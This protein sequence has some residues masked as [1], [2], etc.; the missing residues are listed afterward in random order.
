MY[1]SRSLTSMDASILII[2]KFKSLPLA[3]LLVSR[4]MYSCLIVTSVCSFHT[5]FKLAITLLQVFLSDIACLVNGT[6]FTHHTEAS[7]LTLFYPFSHQISFPFL[8]QSQPMCLTLA[9]AL[10]QICIS[11]RSYPSQSVFKDAAL[12]MSLLWVKFLIRWPFPFQ[13]G[14]I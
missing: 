13:Q 4:H 3:S 5:Q 7:R 14:V 11:C 10:V 1:L 8:S 2:P 6:T 9:P 12:I